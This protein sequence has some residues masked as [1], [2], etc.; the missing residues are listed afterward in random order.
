MMNRLKLLI[1]AILPQRCLW[2]GRLVSADKTACDSCA[3]NL[4]EISGEICEKCGREKKVCNCRGKENYFDGIVAPF[5]Y[6]GAVKKGIHR[7]KFRNRKLSAGQFGA[8]M[9]KAIKKRYGDIKFDIVLPV[10]M[11]EKAVKARTYNQSEL[12]AKE[13]SNKLDIRYSNDILYKL[14]ETKKQHL[15]NYYLRKGNLTG[16]FDVRN[17][18]EIKNKTV[19]LVDDISTTGETL[20]EC[21]KMLWLNGASAVYCVTLALTPSKKKSEKKR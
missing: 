7:F 4:P 13:I 21:S 20:N 1:S 12:L 5:Y 10:P 14:Y 15:L 8:E 6:S 2:C 3:V 17:S 16:V 11:T 9:C 19:L 18:D